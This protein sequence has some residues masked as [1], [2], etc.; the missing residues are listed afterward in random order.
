MQN[1]S[2]TNKIVTVDCGIII[3]LEGSIDDLTQIKPNNP[4]TT[5]DIPPSPFIK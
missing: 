2:Q 3:R 5:P 4:Y 1:T